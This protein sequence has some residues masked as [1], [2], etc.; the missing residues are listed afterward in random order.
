M[1]KQGQGWLN[2]QQLYRFLRIIIPDVSPGQM[3]YLQVML[4]HDG[5]GQISYSNLQHLATLSKQTGI[6]FSVKSGLDATGMYP[7]FQ[8]KYTVETYCYALFADACLT[9]LA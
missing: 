2:V 9:S 7:A 4:D 3:R 1:D 5:D 8:R 6:P